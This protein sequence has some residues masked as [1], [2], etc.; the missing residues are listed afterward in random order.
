MVE[1]Q[2]TIAMDVDCLIP[3]DAQ[4]IIAQCQIVG[5]MITKL[6]AVLETRV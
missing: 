3:E 1:A 2:A 6:V 5:R 4:P